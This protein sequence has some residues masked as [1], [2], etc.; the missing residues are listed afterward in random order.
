MSEQLDDDPQTK[1]ARGGPQ[2][3]L[4]VARMKAKATALAFEVAGVEPAAHEDGETRS[5]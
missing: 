1:E 3:P 4:W 2:D 5:S